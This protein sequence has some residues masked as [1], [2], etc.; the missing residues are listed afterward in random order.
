MP[1][2]DFAKEIRACGNEI[3][4]QVIAYIRCCR[5]G[6]NMKRNE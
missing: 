2:Y 4:K 5:S 6:M 3:Y 1:Q